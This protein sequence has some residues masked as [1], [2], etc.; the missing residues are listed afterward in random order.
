MRGSWQV[1][2]S[3]RSIRSRH[4]RASIRSLLKRESGTE[5]ELGPLHEAPVERTY[6]AG[7]GEE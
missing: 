4:S 2:R 6:D 5:P 1:L 7:E 3:S